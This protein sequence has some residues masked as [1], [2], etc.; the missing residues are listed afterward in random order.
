MIKIS[1]LADIIF[2]LLYLILIIGALLTW[3]P[4]IPIYKQPFKGL[5]MFCDIFFSPFRRIIPPIGGIDFSPI[6]AFFILGFIWRVVVDI[7][8][9]C[10]L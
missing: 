7:L 3:I 8:V 1:L 10:N 2:E 6:L 5:I 9:R 4:R